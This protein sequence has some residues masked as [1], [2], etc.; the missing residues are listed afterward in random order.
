MKFRYNFLVEESDRGLF[1]GTNPAWAW[2]DSKVKDEV[3][4][5]LN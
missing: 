3:V 2:R 4:L 5:V 1:F